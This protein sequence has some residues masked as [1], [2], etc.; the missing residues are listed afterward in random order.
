MWL[1]EKIPRQFKGTPRCSKKQSLKWMQRSNLNKY[2]WDLN[3]DVAA[4][5]EK[6]TKQI[7]QF[8]V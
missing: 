7:E 5:I 4:E 1:K 3:A 2:W 6:S 8:G